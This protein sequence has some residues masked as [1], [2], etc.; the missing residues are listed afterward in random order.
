M[1]D[2]EENMQ[3]GIYCIDCEMM[4]YMYY[5]DGIMMVYLVIL[6]S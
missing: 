6:N 1:R 3:I 2:Y 4:V 5:T